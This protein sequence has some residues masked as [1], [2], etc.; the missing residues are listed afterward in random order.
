MWESK[1]KILAV[2]DSETVRI[3]FKNFLEGHDFKIFEADSGLSAFEVLENNKEIK[4][5]VSDLNMPEMDGMEFIERARKI[6]EFTH[7]PVLVCTTEVCESLKMRAKKLGV[8]VWMQKPVK[9][10]KVLGV[11]NML[12]E[13]L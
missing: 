11:L 12:L 8:R 9:L 10:P 5:I 4:I 3:S 2:D 13:K 7:T 1:L 6:K